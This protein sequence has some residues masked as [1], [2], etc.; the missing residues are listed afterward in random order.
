[1]NHNTLHTDKKVPAWKKIGALAATGLALCPPVGC[2]SEAKAPDAP[3]KAPATTETYQSPVETL[4]PEVLRNMTPEQR[5][6]A[7]KIEGNTPEEIAASNYGKL[8]ALFNS[9]NTT[10]KADKLPA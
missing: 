4:T 3:E 2:A 1:M 9:V 5:E 6:N 8:A 7:F 10:G